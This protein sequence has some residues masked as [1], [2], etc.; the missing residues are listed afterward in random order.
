[1]PLFSITTPATFLVAAMCAQPP[2]TEVHVVGHVEEVAVD[3]QISLGQ[4]REMSAASS[5]R[6]KH[7]PF[8]FYFSAVVDAVTVHIRNDQQ[9]VCSGPVIINVTLTLTQRLIEIGRELKNGNCQ[10]GTFVQHYRH[11]AE[12]DAEIFHAYVGKINKTL[13]D[14]PLPMMVG[15]LGAPGVGNENIA[16]MIRAI[17]NPVLDDMTVAQTKA[18][19]AVDSPAEIQELTNACAGKPI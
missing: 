6:G 10:F 17:M 8:G 9:N 1:M 15:Q 5:R 4:L 16:R 11:H 18:P 13:Q 7:S 2:A 3:S 12:A 14:A 19:D